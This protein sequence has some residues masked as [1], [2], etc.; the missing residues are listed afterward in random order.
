MTKLTPNKEYKFRVK[1]VNMQG[2]SKPLAEEKSIIAKNQFDAP[3]APDKP[4]VTDWDA[5]RIDIAW[6]HPANDGGAPIKQYIIEK[7]ERGSAGWTEAGRVPGSK[8]SFSATGLKEGGEY[9]FRVTAVNEAGP[10]EPSEP[11]DPKKAK[12]RFCKIRSV[13]P[14]YDRPTVMYCF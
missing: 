5:N 6:K 10:G 12:A 4:E 14:L 2:E 1:A 13:L 11:T 8:T 7:K 9:E 3:D